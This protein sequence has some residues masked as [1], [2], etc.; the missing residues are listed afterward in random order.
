MDDKKKE[1]IETIAIL[2]V[3]VILTTLVVILAIVMTR[4]VVRN[5]KATRYDLNCVGTLEE[6]KIK[7]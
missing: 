4:P 2:V 3:N 1:L 6:C 5:S 7:E